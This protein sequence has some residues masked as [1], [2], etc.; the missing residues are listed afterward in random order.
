M[1][2]WPLLD[3][4]SFATGDISGVMARLLHG[5]G[6]L[7]FSGSSA[8]VVAKAKFCTGLPS[9]TWSM[10][11]VPDFASL[12]VA[13]VLALISVHRFQYIGKAVR[14]S[15]TE[16]KSLSQFNL[17]IHQVNISDPLSMKKS[18]STKNNN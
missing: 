2:A 3:F 12:A 10:L 8:L 6:D 7:L 17:E 11:V 14:R 1:V 9:S 18:S 15:K 13:E 5:G 16:K 4:F